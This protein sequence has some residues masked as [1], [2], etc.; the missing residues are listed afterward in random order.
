[1]EFWSGL[2]LWKD[3]VQVSLNLQTREQKLKGAKSLVEITK[4][5][6]QQGLMIP[7]LLISWLPA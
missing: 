5:I 6:K 3:L 1:M 2:D 7:G 4:L